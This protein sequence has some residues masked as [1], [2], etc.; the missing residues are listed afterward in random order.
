MSTKITLT[1][2]TAYDIELLE[3]DIPCRL[4]RLYC[5]VS[6]EKEDGWS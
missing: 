6:F 4:I 1:I 2:S 5:K 3:Q